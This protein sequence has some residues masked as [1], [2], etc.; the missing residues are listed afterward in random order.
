MK[1]AFMRTTRPAVIL[2]AAVL[3]G[4]A[5]GCDPTPTA[6]HDEAAGTALFSSSG[7]A[8]FSLCHRN[9]SDGYTKITIGSPAFGKHMAHGDPVVP[10]SGER[11]FTGTSRLEVAF[12]LDSFDW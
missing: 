8:M 1:E 12:D 11:A 2:A 5:P 10:A 7:Q 3:V 6:L 9:S 4:A